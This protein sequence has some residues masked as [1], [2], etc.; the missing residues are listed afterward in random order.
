MHTNY[1]FLIYVISI[2]IVIFSIIHKHLETISIKDYL[3][4][5]CLYNANNNSIIHIIV[6]VI[7]TFIYTYLVVIQMKPTFVVSKHPKPSLY[8][9]RNKLNRIKLV[10]KHKIWSL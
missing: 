4:I 6:F 5:C 7:P 8:W 2:E 3:Y 1:H 10:S 9:F